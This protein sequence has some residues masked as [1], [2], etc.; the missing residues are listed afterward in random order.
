MAAEIAGGLPICSVKIPPDM[1]PSHSFALTSLRV[2]LEDMNTSR[3]VS[4]IVNRWDRVEERIY[5][6]VPVFCEAICID[7]STFPI[8]SCLW[9]IPRSALSLSSAACPSTEDSSSISITDR[10]LAGVAA[11]PAA[12]PSSSSLPFVGSTIRDAFEGATLRE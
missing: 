8:D 9:I 4:N 6:C 3:G 11:F 5:R 12:S 10:A 1:S 2:A 7:I